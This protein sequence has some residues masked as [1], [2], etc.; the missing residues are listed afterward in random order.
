MQI[1]FVGAGRMDA[2]MVGRLLPAGHDVRVHHRAASGRE[3]PAAD[4]AMTTL[5]VAEPAA[6]A[7]AVV[8]NV[9][10]DEQLREVCGEQGLI[11]SMETGGAWV[12]PTGRSA[13]GRTT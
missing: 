9:Y 6:G 2:P 3:A 8:V 5:V 1:G 12:S 7:R 10:S 11:R 4:G 13:A